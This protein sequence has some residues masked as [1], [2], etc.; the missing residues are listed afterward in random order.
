MWIIGDETSVRA[1][2]RDLMI[3][4]LAFFLRAARNFT[5]VCVF[6]CVPTRIDYRGD[7]AGECAC[8]SAQQQQSQL[9]APHATRAPTKEERVS[10]GR[11]VKPETAECVC[12][13]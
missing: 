10:P 2:A 6:V 4:L 1:T 12:G 3:L 7:A 8:D 9:A 5:C 13:P 11:G